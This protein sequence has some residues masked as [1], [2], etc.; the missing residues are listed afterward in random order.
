MRSILSLPVLLASRLH[1]YSVL[2]RLRLR[3]EASHNSCRLPTTTLVTTSRGVL[4][5]STFALSAELCYFPGRES[6]G[7]LMKP[8]PTS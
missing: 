4:S 2:Y 8:T 7:C 1:S 5:H 6:E 3:L